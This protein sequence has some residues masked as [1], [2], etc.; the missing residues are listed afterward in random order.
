MEYK[1]RGKGGVTMDISGVILL[2][3]FILGGLVGVVMGIFASANAI[4]RIYDFVKGEKDN[5]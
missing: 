3:V 5:E 2:I 1:G 4:G